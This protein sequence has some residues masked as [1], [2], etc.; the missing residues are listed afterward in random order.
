MNK[1]LNA[2]SL[3]DN[4]LENVSAGRAINVASKKP[5]GL[6]DSGGGPPDQQIEETLKD[7][8]HYGPTF[9]LSYTIKRIADLFK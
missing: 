1:N 7:S 9:L 3:D 4:E 5:T 8:I 6:V 2:K